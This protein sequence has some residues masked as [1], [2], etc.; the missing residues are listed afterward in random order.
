MEKKTVV[1]SFAMREEFLRGKTQEEMIDVGQ[2]LIDSV[3]GYKPDLICF[4]EI[5]LK[6]GGDV[7]NPDWARNTQRMLEAYSEKARRL[8]SYILTSAYEPSRRYPDYRYNTSFLIGRD[9][10]LTG[11]YRKVHTVYSESV[12]HHVI[13]GHDYP[14]FDTDFGRIGMQTCFDI[15][16]RNGWQA[17]ADKGARLVVWAAAYDGGNLLD[18]Y[19][20]HN[21]Y[22]VVSTVRTNHARIIDPMGQTIAESARWGSLALASIDLTG[23]IFH[24]DRQWQKIDDIRRALGSKVTIRVLSEENVFWLES[25]SDAWPMDRIRKE[26]GLQTYREY[27]AEATA[28]QKEWREKFRE[29]D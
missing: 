6:T 16:W 20:A 11:K 8:G 12:V 7:D 15:G 26:F 2:T 13:P 22:F 9:G 18:T 29:D 5:F 14:V 3:A 23:D 19:A 1:A 4:P 28:L 27:H 17:L 24:I 21:M 10:T 25:N